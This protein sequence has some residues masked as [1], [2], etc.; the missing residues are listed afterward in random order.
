MVLLIVADSRCVKLR[1]L[2]CVENLTLSVSVL[3]ASRA[4]LD[5][6]LVHALQLKTVL[7][8]VGVKD[9]V[10]VAIVGLGGWRE[11]TWLGLLK[12]LLVVDKDIIDSSFATTL[13]L[14]EAANFV[15]HLA[16][17]IT[18]SF[19]SGVQRGRCVCCRV[20]ASLGDVTILEASI[21]RSG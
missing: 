14:R 17:A 21:L 16:F 1:V 18:L 15:G 10:L 9:G 5:T 11:T 20:E 6:A 2:I 7:L 13:V 3:G 12:L 19:I 8:L 4:Y